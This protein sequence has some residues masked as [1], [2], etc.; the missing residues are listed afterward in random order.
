MVRA[1]EMVTFGVLLTFN[2]SVGFI[3]T[4]LSVLLGGND[5]SIILERVEGLKSSI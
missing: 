4:R 1:W 5:P 2:S 3:Y